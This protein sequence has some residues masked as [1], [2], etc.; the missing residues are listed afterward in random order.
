V[1]IVFVSSDTS[2][3]SFN[4][5]FSGMSWHALPYEDR[6]RKALLCKVFDVRSIP[7]LLLFNSAGKL[8][9]KNGVEHVTKS[10][11]A[12][13]TVAGRVSPLTKAALVSG[14]AVPPSR[15]Y[16]LYFSASWCGPCKRF[17]P[18][19]ADWYL[20]QRQGNIDPSVFEVLFVSADRN[21]SDFAAYS[22][23]MPWKTVDYGDADLLHQHYNI[24]SL[25]TLL[26]VDQDGSVLFTDAMTLV[27]QGRP[28]PWN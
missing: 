3:A 12:K 25:P 26:L 23:D 11:A 5:Y 20:K 21:Q 28:F 13:P 14:R 7:A 18:V 27:Q 6:Q 2:E 1:H 8:V 16:C 22:A 9:S 24:S 15:Y 17:T 10:L 4:Q 19:L